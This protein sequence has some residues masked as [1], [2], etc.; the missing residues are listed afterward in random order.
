MKA[1]R[2]SLDFAS[3]KP[4][5][6]RATGWLLLLGSIALVGVC[7]C[8]ADA[9]REEH[10]LEQALAQAERDS[11]ALASPAPRAPVTEPR[12]LARDR[13]LR[14]VTRSLSTPWAD[15]F[16]A[17]EAAPTDAVALLSIEPS[18]TNRSVRLSAEARDAK[19]MLVYLAALQHDVRLSRV[20]LV[21]HQVQA[22]TPGTPVRF[23]IQALWADAR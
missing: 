16:A 2:L 1:P 4:G 5:P 3:A 8:V 11:T 12:Q 9:M 17:L 20:V 18:V 14:E 19:A 23:Q 6:L 13:A 22:Q 10:A 15:L 7:L 21:A